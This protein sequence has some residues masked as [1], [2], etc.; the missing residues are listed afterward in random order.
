MKT[1]KEKLSKILRLYYAAARWNPAGWM[2][3]HEKAIKQITKLFKG[4]KD[5]K[6]EKPA[7]EVGRQ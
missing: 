5:E 3:A 7:S 4:E 2:C 6:P 1:T